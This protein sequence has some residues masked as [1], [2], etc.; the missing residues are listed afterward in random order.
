M[1]VSAPYRWYV[2]A[3]FR[4]SAARVCSVWASCF[5]FEGRPSWIMQTRP[6]DVGYCSSVFGAG[7]CSVP[8]ARL[9][10]RCFSS[11]RLLESSMNRRQSLRVWLA[12]RHPQSSSKQWIVQGPSSCSLAVSLL[13]PACLLILVTWNDCEWSSEREWNL[14]SSSIPSLIEWFRINL[15]N[16]SGL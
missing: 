11:L 8:Q 16:S 13:E 5:A 14:G 12:L 3:V 1:F 7:D 2:S 10:S 9:A 6:W 15:A 4:L